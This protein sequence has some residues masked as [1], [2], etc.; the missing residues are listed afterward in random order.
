MPLEAI[1]IKWDRVSAMVLG[2]LPRV[3]P[4]EATLLL[5][6]AIFAWSIWSSQEEIKCHVPERYTS[7]HSCKLWS[8]GP[9]QTKLIIWPRGSPSMGYRFTDTNTSMSEWP[10]LKDFNYNSIP[11]CNISIFR[12]DPSVTVPDRPWRA[13]VRLQESLSSKR[14]RVWVEERGERQPNPRSGRV[15]CHLFGWCVVWILY[16]MRNG[17]EEWFYVDM[18]VTDAK[19]SSAWW[20]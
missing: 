20:I 1:N 10:G 8:V 17:V 9:A 6:G 3:K 13:D 19:F 11:L 16:L 18:D 12:L 7:F 14:S 5:Q 2:A 15:M 4:V